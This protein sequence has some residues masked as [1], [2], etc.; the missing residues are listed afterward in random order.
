M[1][2]RLFV[3]TKEFDKQWERLGLSDY[4]L[5]EVQN[6]LLDDP[7]AAPVIQGTGGLRK[8]RLAFRGKGK[9]GGIRLIYADF[10]NYG[11][12]FLIYAYAKSETDD[13]SP[14]ARE[15]FKTYIEVLEKQLKG[16]VWK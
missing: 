3:H 16:G 11:I 10:E 5:S 1:E 14:E 15:R 9:S 2:S 6:K 8:I 7:K 12:T 13:L 4:D